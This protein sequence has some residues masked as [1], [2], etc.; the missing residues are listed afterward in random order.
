MFE[1]SISLTQ[2]NEQERM[3]EWALWIYVKKSKGIANA[4]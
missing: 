4:A 3:F 2:E 1:G